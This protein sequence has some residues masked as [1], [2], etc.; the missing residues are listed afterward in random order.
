LWYGFLIAISAAFIDNYVTLYALAL[1][2][3]SLQVGYLSSAS[4][5][6]GMIAP[7]PGAQWAARWGKRKSVV[8]ISFALRRLMELLTLIVPF[9]VPAQTAIVL[10]IVLFALRAGFGNLGTPP[11]SSLAADLVPIEWRGRYFSGRKSL[12]AA[13][14]LLCAAGRPDHRVVGAAARL[15]GRLYD[16]HCFRDRRR[17]VLRLHPRTAPQR[18]GAP[19]AKLQ[20]FLA[21][22]DRKPDVLAVHA[23]LDGV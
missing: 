6:Y 12:M 20:R 2:A 9:L 5:L 13:A 21:L 16:L 22:A 15:S 1:G 19:G 7:I 8:V 14:S 3:T 18:G 11:W 4:S 23:L 17:D 10:I